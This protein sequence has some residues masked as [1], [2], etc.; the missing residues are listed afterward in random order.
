MNHHRIKK[1]KLRRKMETGVTCPVWPTPDNDVKES[2]RGC[3]GST[4]RF[5]VPVSHSEALDML[6]YSDASED[7]VGS[8]MTKNEGRS[9][10]EVIM[11]SGLKTKGE[12]KQDIV[13]RPGVG[14]DVP[15]PPAPDDAARRNR[16]EGDICVTNEEDTNSVT[17]DDRE[18]QSIG[19]QEKRRSSPRQLQGRICTG[20]RLSIRRKPRTARLRQVTYFNN[21]GDSTITTST[22]STIAV[23]ELETEVAYEAEIAR[24]TSVHDTPVVVADDEISGVRSKSKEGKSV[25]TAGAINATQADRDETLLPSPASLAR[26][27]MEGTLEVLGCSAMLPNCS[28]EDIVSKLIEQM[29]ILEKIASSSGYL[30]SIHV[31]TIRERSRIFQMSF[32]HACMLLSSLDDVPRL[33]EK[34]RILQIQ[35]RERTAE[36]EAMRR[37]AREMKQTILSYTER[38]EAEVQQLSH[39]TIKVEAPLLPP[40]EKRRT[41][42]SKSPP[43]SVNIKGKEKGEEEKSS[44]LF[45]LILEKINQLEITIA[46]MREELLKNREQTLSFQRKAETD[47]QSQIEDLESKKKQQKEEKVSNGTHREPTPPRRESIIQEDIRLKDEQEPL[48]VASSTAKST[49]Q[50]ETTWKKVVGRKEARA[51]KKEAASRSSSQSQATAS[52]AAGG[53]QKVAKQKVAKPAPQSPKPP[54]TATVILTHGEVMIETKAKVNLSDAGITEVISEIVLEIP[55]EERAIKAEAL[56]RLLSKVFK[57]SEATIVH[58][59]TYADFRISQMDDSVTSDEVATVVAATAGCSEKDLKVGTVKMGSDSLL[60]VLVRC[61]LPAANK[62]AAKKRITVGWSSSKIM[63]LPPGNLLRCFRCIDDGP[64]RPIAD[65]DKWFRWAVSV[66]YGCAMP[67]TKGD[68]RRTAYWW[69]DDIARLRSNCFAARRQYQRA[70]RKSSSNETLEQQLLET[71]RE[72]KKTMQEAIRG[73]K[74]R[75]R[76]AFLESANHDPCCC[77]YKLVDTPS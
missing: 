72:K 65:V 11:S 76:N 36:L 57:E 49:A 30:E 42:F 63:I 8:V 44:S 70:R 14:G 33:Q 66:M 10:K 9:S 19:S 62:I 29:L 75:A 12:Y 28:I 20:R 27:L 13:A 46:A 37:E 24:G 47:P 26:A 68:R 58:P 59:I 71:Y 55:L 32:L 7:C 23:E 56:A 38:E 41:D 69:T 17:N 67:Q 54:K 25:G 45:Q 6:E 35:L 34:V 50:A 21:D 22:T 74:T 40:E 73:A 51:T 64:T 31:K 2:R 52:K 15:V 4:V 1:R 60:A 53:K 5:P 3:K 16:G 39:Q 61:P 77:P 43:E 48:L 18:A